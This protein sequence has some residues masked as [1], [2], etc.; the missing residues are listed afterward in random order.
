[1]IM[2]PEARLTSAIARM[3]DF[4]VGG[5]ACLDFANTVEPRGGTDTCQPP[6]TAG[7]GDPRRDYLFSYVDFIAWSHVAGLIPDSEASRFISLSDTH[8]DDAAVIFEQAIS[9]RESIY[10]VSLAI[11]RS[12]PP[13]PT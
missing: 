10:R 11:S 4:I 13:D 5:A 2:D 1:M 6:E 7:S 12:I 3:P 9:L 8:T